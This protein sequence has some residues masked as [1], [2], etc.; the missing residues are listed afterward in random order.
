MYKRQKWRKIERHLQG[1]PQH[2]KTVYEDVNMVS[3]VVRDLFSE[4]FKRILVDEPRL[5]KNLKGYVQAVAPALADCVKYHDSSRP[6]F[7]A[8]GIE[9][10]LRLAFEARVPMPS[11]GYLIIERTE[12]MHVVDVNSGRA[13]KGLSQEENA[14][15]VD[16]E[17]A[18]TVCRHLR[19]RDLGG[20]ICVDFIDLRD[21]KNRRKVLDLSLIHI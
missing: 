14:L 21:E 11:G 15:R 6:V 2:P 16:L 18:K 17:A 7:E 12:A 4:D 20:I 19:L 1:R 5:F 10:Q 8:V 3:S 13:G 9:Q